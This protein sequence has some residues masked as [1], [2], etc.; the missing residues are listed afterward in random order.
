[1]HLGLA[2]ARVMA[3]S[4]PIPL[5]LVPVMRTVPV[6]RSS[7][8]YKLGNGHL[9]PLAMCLISQLL[10]CLSSFGI[11]IERSHFVED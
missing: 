3:V 5:A 6:V 4:A 9:T 8:V 10:D 11:S 2:E 1:M 7:E